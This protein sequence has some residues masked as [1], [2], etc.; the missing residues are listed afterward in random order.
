M[1]FSGQA[2]RASAGWLFSGLMLLCSG[3]VYAQNLITALNVGYNSSMTLI[4][5]D[6]ARPL[7]R[8]PDT[9]FIIGSSPHIVL[10]FPDTASGLDEPVQDFTEGGLRSANIVQSGGRTRLVLYLN[11][12]FP[13]ST[14]ID[15][16]S[17]LITLQGNAGNAGSVALRS[18]ETKQDAQ[19]LALNSEADAR[20]KAEQE[21]QAA[22]DEKARQAAEAKAAKIKAMEEAKA[23]AA[24]LKA[25]QKAK[26]E[27][28]AQA[29]QAAKTE[30][31]RLLAEQKA[32]AQVEKQAVAKA[33]PALLKAEPV[34]PIRPQ[35]PPNLPLSGEERFSSPP[36]K[37]EPVKFNI[38]EFQV[39]GNTL[40]PV[41]E[42][43]SAL[44]PFTGAGREMADVNK[45]VEALRA[46]YH[47]AGY[48]VVQVVFPV[49]TMTSGKAL[50]LKVVEDKIASI[51][52]KGNVAYDADNIRASLPPLQMGKSLN[53]DRLEAAIAL[54]N[55]NS[56]KQVTVNVQPG[57]RPGDINTRIDV[58]EDR[59]SKFIATY[60]NTGSTA[61]GFNPDCSLEQHLI[62]K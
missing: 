41:D 57:V 43:G 48:S 32:K 31:A 36:D 42:I 47:E 28:D 50:L 1:K 54:A 49:Q 6:L 23:E 44:S 9:E 26:I 7:A 14:R 20:L 18:A 39:E 58:A 37:G 2:S 61:T 11:Q 30:A 51:D 3:G 55:E 40:L 60:D 25:E 12:M 62:E 53:A 10:E 33:E 29:M 38:A 13:S 56:A 35:T 22:A 21:T 34:K 17:L 16:N 19:R 24:R 15:G 45:A 46:L 27:A 8:V 52:V 5:I 4:K 59:V